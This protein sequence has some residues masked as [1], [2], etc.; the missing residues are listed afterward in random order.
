MNGVECS[1]CR[2]HRLRGAVEDD[3]IDLDEFQ[4]INERKDG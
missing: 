3:S 1:K 2:W 4:R